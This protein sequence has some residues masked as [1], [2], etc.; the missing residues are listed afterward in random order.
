MISS[1]FIGGRKGIGGV[2]LGSLSG[3]SVPSN[4]T[5]TITVPGAQSATANIALAITGTSLSDA[6][7]NP[8]TITITT[9]QSGTISLASTTG[10]TGSGDGTNSLSYSGSLANINTALATLTYTSALN[11]DGSEIISIGTNDGASGSDSKT[12]AVTV[13]LNPIFQDAYG[14]HTYGE[15]AFA[16]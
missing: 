16:G 10:L 12:I 1:V 2:G 6:D 5:P 3:I 11:Y 15:I 14:S 7:G 8:Q 4:Q 13:T 9:N